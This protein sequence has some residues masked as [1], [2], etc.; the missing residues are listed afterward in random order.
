MGREDFPIDGHET[1]PHGGPRLQPG[2]DLVVPVAG[3]HPP[4][5]EQGHE[6]GAESPLMDGAFNRKRADDVLSGAVDMLGLQVYTIDAAGHGIYC[7][8]DHIRIGDNAP[9]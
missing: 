2:F 7:I 3:K 6:Q 5:A 8:G 9:G 4:R 1:Q